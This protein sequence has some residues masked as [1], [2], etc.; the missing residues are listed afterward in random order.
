MKRRYIALT[1]AVYL[2]TSIPYV[3]GYLRQSAHERFTGVVFDVVDTAQYYAWMRAFT[4]GPLIANPLTPDSGSERF[5]NLQWWLLGIISG[6]SPLGATIVYQGLRVVALAGFAWMLARFCRL[7]AGQ[8][9]FFA[10]ALVMLS[11][12]LGWLL[13]VAKQWSGELRWPL[14]VQ[15]AEPNTWFSAMAFP[16]L[17][18]A[19]G[20]MLAIY[21]LFLRATAAATILTRFA[22][23][24][25]RPAWSP[26]AAL[27]GLTL[28]L[29]FSHGY[30]LLPVIAVPGVY[31]GVQVL[32][33]R[34]LVAG[35]WPAAAICAGAALPAI[36]TLSLTTLDPTW[37]GVLSQ[38]GNAGV[39]TPPIPQ[40]LI[41][42]GIPL[43]LALP[44]LR[45]AEWKQGSAAG[46]FVRCWFV[47]G[48]ALLYIPTDYQV[49]ML[50]GWQVPVC[51]LAAETLVD[52]GQMLSRRRPALSASRVFRLAPLA[53]LGAIFLT[54]AYL[55]AWRVTD[56]RRAEYPYYLSSGDVRALES[57]D[58]A[59]SSVVV[60]SSPDLG[61]WVPVYADA[62]PYVAHWAQ[63][64]HFL[65]RRD[66]AAWFFD[67][68]TSDTD[69]DAF[70][71]VNGIDLVLSGPAEARIGGGAYPPELALDRVVTG[72]TSVYVTRG[73][74]AGR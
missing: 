35:V 65:E 66:A 10:F 11:S 22:W 25:A 38:Y 16:H 17:L 34:R 40:L 72:E 33:A 7:V 31:T 30:D 48:F 61:V 64:L 13:V 54:N 5:F 68:A 57:L 20:L 42:M 52:F 15:I 70:L 55:T 2:V 6:G 28:A 18:A 74:Q 41:L 67:P 44:R 29:G 1:A 27:A 71:D 24:P 8:Q 14:S 63:T 43:L 26:L 46:Q 47:V 37:E 39:Y 36:Y 4:H 69:R 58:G 21:L 62:R 50:T 56:L 3:Y 51:L 12:G 23:L 45:P 9:A 32:R 53:V 73:G 49:K 60:L 19:A 59:D